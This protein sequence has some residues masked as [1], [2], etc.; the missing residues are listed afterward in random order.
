MNQRDSS[1]QGLGRLLNKTLKKNVCLPPVA[2]EELLVE[3]SSVGAQEVHGVQL[4]DV[5]RVLDR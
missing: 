3:D 2:V 1:L 4:A 5:D